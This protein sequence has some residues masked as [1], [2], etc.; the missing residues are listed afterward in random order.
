MSNPYSPGNIL[1]VLISN[2]LFI[3]IAAFAIYL[4]TTPYYTFAF[5][6]ILALITIFVF[7]KR[8]QYALFL[9]IFL[10]P[11]DI[12]RESLSSLKFLS[13]SKL[14]GVI[15]IAIVFFRLVMYKQE[16][17]RFKSNLWPFFVLFLTVALISATMSDFQET[18][19]DDVRKMLTVYMFFFLSLA[20]VTNKHIKE[21]LPGVFIWSVSLASLLSV[22]GYV[23]DISFFAMDISGKTLKRGVGASNDPNFFSSM[24]VFVTPFIINR[25]F[26]NYD[27]KTKLIAVL[28]LVV[29]VGGLVLTFSRTGVFIFALITVA[30]LLIYR[31]KVKVKQMGFF[32]LFIAMV[33]IAAKVTIPDKFWQRQLTLSRTG[34]DSISRRI[35]YLY[36]GWDT[37]R[38]H[39]FV[40]TGPGTFHELYALSKYVTAYIDESAEGEVLHGSYYRDAHNSYLEIV[41]GMGAGGIVTI[42]L[43]F[44]VVIRNFL[45]SIKQFLLNGDIEMAL[46][47]KTYLMSFMSQAISYA[48]LSFVY[49]KYIWLL[50][51]VSQVVLH[52]AKGQGD[53][54]EQGVLLG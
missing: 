32:L 28:L 35:T 4:F 12:F 24:I 6:P 3:A 30:S 25:L 26:G 9:M 5:V 49:Q 53:Q 13:V 27:V 23:F 52:A 22:A 1:S 48:F 46:L 17:N 41:V 29:N 20:I 2:S 39:P 42:L 18:A 21:T 34:D 37:F 47:S 14:L 33:I 40:G 54:K 43:I 45:K 8:P 36:V 51:A 50:I 31:D 11:F 15:L 7:F 19:F 10:V 44:A 16:V 38:E